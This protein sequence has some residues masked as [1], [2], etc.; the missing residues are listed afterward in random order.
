M[1]EH[2]QE[3]GEYGVNV[4]YE[5]IEVAA[6]NKHKDDIVEMM[7]KGL[8]GALKGRGVETVLGTA[9]FTSPTSVSMSSRDVMF[10]PVSPAS[11][12]AQG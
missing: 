10:T 9:T 6:L 2:A 7:W 12:T 4:S 5:G 3:A 1:A 11:F 8:Q